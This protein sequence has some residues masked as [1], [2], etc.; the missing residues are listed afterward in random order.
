MRATYVALP[1]GPSLRSGLCCPGPSSLNQPHPPHSQAH[2]NFAVRW[3]ICDAFAVRERLGD[4]RAVPSFRCTF[5]LSMSPSMSPGSRSLHPSSSF[6]TRACL[7]R[8]LPAARHSQ[9]YPISG[10]PGSPSLRPA[11]L[12]ASLAGDFYSRAF[13][14]LVTLPVAGYNYGGN[15]TISTGGTLTRWNGS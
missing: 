13:N 5:L 10:L 11:E 14:G 1:Q 9:R 3:L 6:T 12:L 15:W 2:H 7:R 8:E 4:P